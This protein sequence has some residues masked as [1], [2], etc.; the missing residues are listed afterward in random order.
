M[1]RRYYLSYRHSVCLIMWRWWVRYWLK[2]DFQGGARSSRFSFHYKSWPVV[3]TSW[4]VGLLA[5]LCWCSS[6]RTVCLLSGKGELQVKWVWSVLVLRMAQIGVGLVSMPH[7][8][9]GPRPW[10]EARVWG[11]HAAVG[12]CQ[13]VHRQWPVVNMSKFSSYREAVMSRLPTGSTFS[14]C[15]R[16]RCR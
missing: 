11:P 13:V 6:P 1:W 5:V 10:S 12:R 2:A 7:Q 15:L 4:Y 3:G 16:H 14:C 8:S 9:A